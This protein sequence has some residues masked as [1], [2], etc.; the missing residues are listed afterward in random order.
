MYKVYLS[1]N[2]KNVFVKNFSSPYL[3]KRF[4]KKIKYSTSVNLLF[5]R[6]EEL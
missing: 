5:Y 6:Y 1:D 3:F 4:M 2:N